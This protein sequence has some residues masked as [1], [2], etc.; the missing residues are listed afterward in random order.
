MDDREFVARFED[1]TLPPALFD[2]RNHVRLAWLYL[3]EEPLLTAMIR[4]KASLKRYAGSLGAAAKY[5][6]TITIA[7]LLLI[8]ER[9]GAAETFDQFADANADL[10]GPLLERYYSKEAL[11]SEEARREFVMPDLSPILPFAPLAGGR[12]PQGG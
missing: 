1:C 4:F 2:H 6:E 5:H 11:A 8:H 7:F 10:F 12:C 3:K 9:M